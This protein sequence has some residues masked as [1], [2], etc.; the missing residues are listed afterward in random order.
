MRLSPT[1]VDDSRQQI[2]SGNDQA[3]DAESSRAASDPFAEA[4]HKSLQAA[5]LWTL[6]ETTRRIVDVHCARAMQASSASADVAASKGRE[7]FGARRQWRLRETLKGRRLPPGTTEPQAKASPSVAPQ[8]LTAP[9]TEPSSQQSGFRLEDFSSLAPSFTN[10]LGQP[11][12]K[13]ATSLRGLNNLGNTCY[14]N[15]LLVG[16]SRLP[17]VLCW[18]SEHA[19]SMD[20]DPNYKPRS[21]ITCTLACDL[22]H[23]TGTTANTPFPPNTMKNISQWSSTF[24]PGVQQDA[25][26]AFQYIFAACDAVDVRHLRIQL[27]IASRHVMPQ[28]ALKAT[29][30]YEVFGG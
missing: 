1:R 29:P 3:P 2:S 26:E 24:A 16:L 4:R 23:L 11:E 30:Y 25:E 12:P 19:H 15:A 21:C 27:Q 13:T 22:E 14:G 7:V 17:L 18:F 20:A 10:V 5:K 9:P 28:Q 8:T 6:V